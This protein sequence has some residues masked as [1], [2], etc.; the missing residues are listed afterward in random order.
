MTFWRPR[1]LPTLAFGRDGESVLSTLRDLANELQRAVTSGIGDQNALG[2]YL[3][4]ISSAEKQLRSAF[5]GQ[6]AVDA[7]HTR[8]FWF[9]L[10]IDKDAE[11]WR[12]LQ[13]EVDWQLSILAQYQDQPTH[14]IDVFRLDECE[15]AVILDTN[16]LLHYD[17]IDD[18][19]WNE[20]LPARGGHRL[21]I[22]A[23]VIKERDD[24]KIHPKLGRTARAVIRSLYE[25]RDCQ[26]NGVTGV[27]GV[28][29]WW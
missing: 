25:M 17:L 26:V 16:F 5:N 15:Q 29:G 1:P 9:L 4:W 2:R 13:D 22:P 3:G 10:E 6:E 19:V 23:V 12:Q 20:H 8:R 11:P 7:L 21:V 27:G 14:E 18:V 24:K 28:S